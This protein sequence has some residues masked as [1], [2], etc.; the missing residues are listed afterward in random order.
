MQGQSTNWGGGIQKA[1]VQSRSFHDWQFLYTTQTSKISF[2]FKEIA[3]SSDAGGAKN[4]FNHLSVCLASGMVL[5]TRL[6][7]VNKPDMVLKL[8]KLAFSWARRALNK[9]TSNLQTVQGQ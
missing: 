8:M 9:L 4:S 5:A 3:N 1:T 7:D 6:A 2:F